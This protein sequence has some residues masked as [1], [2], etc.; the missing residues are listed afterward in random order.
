VHQLTDYLDIVYNIIG[1][2]DDP[3]TPEG[4]K[5]YLTAVERFRKLIS[6]PWFSKLLEKRSLTIVD[7]GAG[8]GIGGV[9]LAR[10]LQESGIKPRVYMIDVR[11]E[12]LKI[13]SK[14]ASE[15]SIEAETYVVDAKEVHKVGIENVDLVLMYGGMLAHFNE[16][17]L[18][19]LFSSTTSIINDEGILILEELDRDHMLYTHGYKEL[20]VERRDEDSVTISVHKRYDPITGSYYRLFID[21]LKRKVVEASINFRSIAQIASLL[22]IFMHD[23]DIVYTGENLTYYILGT[24]PRR[25]INIGDLTNVPEVLKRGSFWR[26]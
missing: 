16:W 4:Y 10:V 15:N 11:E 19:K 21:L 8:K 6:H 17:D 5:R 25:K 2:K 7:V 3:Y 9:A 26:V 1:W 20:S 18:V 12:A 22:W 14:F 13:A 23:I 24:K